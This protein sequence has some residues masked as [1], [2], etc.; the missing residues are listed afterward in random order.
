MN[1]WLDIEA[2]Q[3]HG[4]FMRTKNNHA[5]KAIGK[6]EMFVL[7]KFACFMIFFFF[8]MSTSLEAKTLHKNRKKHAE[9]KVMIS[10]YWN[11]VKCGREIHRYFDTCSRCGQHRLPWQNVW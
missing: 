4:E 3:I 5:D 2:E 8:A 11:C 10:Q 6:K 1:N 7:A 9:S